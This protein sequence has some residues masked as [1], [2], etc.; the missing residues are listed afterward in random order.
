MHPGSS[1]GGTGEKW[2][3][4]DTR[5]ACGS[6]Q[7]VVGCLHL[8]GGLDILVEESMEIPTIILSHAKPGSNGDVLH[9]AI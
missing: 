1:C 6:P 9:I 2:D 5:R 7:V 8:V 3:S 4:K